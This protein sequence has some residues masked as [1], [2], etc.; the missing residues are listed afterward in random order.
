MLRGCHLRVEVG[1]ASVTYLVDGDGP[2]LQ[3]SHHGTP[4]SVAPG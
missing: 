2:P 1:P 4:V 3:I